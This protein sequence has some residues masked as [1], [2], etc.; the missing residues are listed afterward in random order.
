MSTPC[1][2]QLRRTTDEERKKMVVL[3][4]YQCLLCRTFFKIATGVVIA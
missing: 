1:L 2:H 3:Y 4:R